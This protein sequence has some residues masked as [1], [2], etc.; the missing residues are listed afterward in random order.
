MITTKQFTQTLVDALNDEYLRRLQESSAEW[1]KRNEGQTVSGSS[2][3]TCLRLCH[4]R[5][6]ENGYAKDP[7]FTD[8]LDDQA[9]RYMH[10]GL[11][12]EEVVINALTARGIPTGGYVHK[13]QLGEPVVQQYN[14]GG[15]AISAA[16]DLT[17]ECKDDDGVYYI[18]TEIKTTD[19]V[20][21]RKEG[22][23]W[24]TPQK[25][26]DNFEGRDSNITQLA[27][28]IHIAKLNGY[29]VPFGVIFY[30]RRATWDVRLVVINVDDPSIDIHEQNEV[31]RV[32]DY[33]MLEPDIIARNEQ[34]KAAM[35]NDVEPEYDPTIPKYVCTGCNYYNKCKHLMGK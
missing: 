1:E 26:W 3:A 8:K 21:S 2:F 20:F 23:T 5:F 18:P 32:I 7:A 19:R 16:N 34:L 14:M 30:L 35:V 13:E 10:F 31:V 24:V 28:W 22:D 29:R 17:T 4:F 12:A 6:K 27:Q 25:W 9:K 11:L 33:A 15:Y